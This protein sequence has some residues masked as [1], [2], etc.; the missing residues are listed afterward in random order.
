M[1]TY[2][3]KARVNSKV[4]SVC[5]LLFH[6][7]LTWG[8]LITIGSLAGLEARLA[9]LENTTASLQQSNVR[10]TKSPDGSHRQRSIG[11]GSLDDSNTSIGDGNSIQPLKKRKLMSPEGQEPPSNVTDCPPTHYAGEA[12]DVINEELGSNLRIPPSRRAVLESALDLVTRFTNDP[13]TQPD[14]K[15]S[16]KPQEERAP[17]ATLLPELMYMMFTGKLSYA[18][19]VPDI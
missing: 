2:S 16:S 9:N 18:R 1:P 17:V 5:F 6:S 15:G 4:D 14:P 8:I 12:R 7:S 3:S 19:F 10:P 11:S 13:Q